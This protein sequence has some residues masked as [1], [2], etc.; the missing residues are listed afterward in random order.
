MKDKDNVKQKG[1]SCL[2]PATD[3]EQLDALV[4]SSGMKQKAFL[5]RLVR[6]AV[7]NSAKIL[8]ELLKG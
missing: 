1:F 6:Y 7:R 5:L 8:P 3:K 4:A 2:M